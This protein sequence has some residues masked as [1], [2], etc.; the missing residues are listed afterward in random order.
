MIRDLGKYQMYISMARQCHGPIEM[1]TDEL[2][3]TIDD[4][5]ADCILLAGHA[6]CK[7]VWAAMKIV[8][9]MCKR[10]GIPTMVL[11][12]DIMD[13]RHTPETEIRRKISDFFRSHGWA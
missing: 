4:Y 1:I 2:E 13:K 10:K 9:D 3:K 5:S 7:H 6:G 12:I 8:E 11:E